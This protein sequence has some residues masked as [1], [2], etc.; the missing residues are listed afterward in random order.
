M[1]PIHVQNT[2]SGLSLISL[3]NKFYHSKVFIIMNV[4]NY[5]YDD[6]GRSRYFKG[7]NVGDCV[8]RAITIASGRDYKEVY[9]SLHK[10]LGVT[11]RDGVWTS[12]VPFKRW[13]KEN[14][15]E[16]HTCS[17]IGSHEAVHF[18]DGELPHFISDAKGIRPARLVCSVAKH[19]VAVVNNEVHDTWDSRYNAWGDL[20]RIYGYWIYTL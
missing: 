3:L 10:A 12:R 5:I 20:R 15:F 19:N 8:V 14:G 11:P 7:K 17:G 4:L 9:D 2:F 6:G 13:M 16:W 18:I 1:S